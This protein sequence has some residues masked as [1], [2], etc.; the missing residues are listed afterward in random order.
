MTLNRLT[1]CQLFEIRAPIWNGGKKMVGLNIGRIGPH[2]EIRFTYRR[3][4]DG[5][6][7]IPDA[8]YFDGNK[9]KDIDYT[10]QNVKGTTLVLIPFSDLEI[11]ERA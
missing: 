11:L 5:E 4:S 9:L 8:Y 3:K 2:N 7:S 10:R 1:P 6:L